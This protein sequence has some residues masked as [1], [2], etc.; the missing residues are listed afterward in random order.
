MRGGL[1]QL[2]RRISA[3][4]PQALIPYRRQASAAVHSLSAKEIGSSSVNQDEIAHFSRLS[5]LWWDEQGEF[6]L[7]HKM[8]PVRVQFIR[9]RVVR[10]SSWCANW[11]LYPMEV[12]SEAGRWGGPRRRRKTPGR[13][14]RLRRWLWWRPPHRGP[15]IFTLSLM[16]SKMTTPLPSLSIMRTDSCSSWSANSWH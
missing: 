9:E 16:S 7:L 3:L 11:W 12:R 1:L 4:R 14:R 8:N 5:A 10:P 13:S 6:G 2:Q 15:C